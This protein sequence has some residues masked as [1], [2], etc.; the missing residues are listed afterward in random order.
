M[1]KRSE[2]RGGQKRSG[3]VKCGRKQGSKGEGIRGR[4]KVE[5]SQVEGKRGA[6]VSQQKNELSITGTQKTSVHAP[7]GILV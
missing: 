4:E 3:G 1:K 2:D 5:G 6:V 7:Y